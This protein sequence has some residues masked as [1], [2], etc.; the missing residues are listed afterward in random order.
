MSELISHFSKNILRVIVNRLKA[1]A[2]ELLTEEQQVL[3]Q[4]GAQ[5]VS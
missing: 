3:D 2:E 4:A 1:K 5:L